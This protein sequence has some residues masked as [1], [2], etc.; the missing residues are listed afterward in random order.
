MSDTE[1]ETTTSSILEA[2]VPEVL[3]VAPKKKRGG[4]KKK[5]I[6]DSEPNPE[7]ENEVLVDPIVLAKLTKIKPIK[8]KIAISKEEHERLL[9]A[10][11]NQAVKDIQARKRAEAQAAFD[12]LALI[13]ARLA[14]KGISYE[15]LLASSE[16]EIE[17]EP[18]PRRV[19]VAHLQR[20]APIVIRRR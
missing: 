14:K 10:K 12:K 5:P 1:Q 17:T 4:S 15:D 19:R 9:R 16:S 20:D 6:N 8:K 2:V 18:E 3:P 7:N 13:D 11:Q